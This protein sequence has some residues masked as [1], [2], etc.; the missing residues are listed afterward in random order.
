[1]HGAHWLWRAPGPILTRAL[2]CGTLPKCPT[3]GWE[4]PRQLLIKVFQTLR[5][6]LPHGHLPPD[7]R[8]LPISCH[9]EGKAETDKR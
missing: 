5:P 2:L 4:S 7:G 1:M 8:Q 3:I 9:S 6:A